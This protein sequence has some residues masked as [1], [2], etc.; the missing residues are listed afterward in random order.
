MT[1]AA[2]PAYDFW[3]GHACTLD[4]CEPCWLRAGRMTNIETGQSWRFTYSSPGLRS[5]D[6][7][8][9]RMIEWLDGA[10]PISEPETTADPEMMDGRGELRLYEL[11]PT[12]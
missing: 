7:M 8:Y 10:L 12:A 11:R 2:L 1:A 4:I 6:P 9:E 5:G 3:N